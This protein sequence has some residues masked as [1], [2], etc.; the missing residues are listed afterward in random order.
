MRGSV[1]IEG[2]ESTL[3][4][5]DKEVD[6]VE[7]ATRAG[8]RA[9]GLKL[10]G[11]SQLQ[12]P[13]RLGDLVRSAYTRFTPEDP[14]VIEVGYS[15]A[16]ALF[17]HQMRMVNA[18]QPRP[19]PYPGVLWGPQGKPRYLEDPF[20]AMTQDIISTIEEYVRAAI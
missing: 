2:L 8:L 5:L 15:I 1:V 16:Y 11:V 9:A 12:A 6:K 3:R 18:G 19:D 14:D 7:R 4:D 13:H 10:Q 20:E 17:V